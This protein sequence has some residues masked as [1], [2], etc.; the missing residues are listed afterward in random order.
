MFSLID[1]VPIFIKALTGM[2]VVTCNTVEN[3][4]AMI[5]SKDEI[6]LDQKLLL[7]VGK[8]LEDGRTLSDYNIEKQSTL[9]M[10]LSLRGQELFCTYNDLCM[11]IFVV[12]NRFSIPS[13]YILWFKD[14]MLNL[15]GSVE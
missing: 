11:A 12:N 1:G 15:D 3:V 14:L 13:L 9:H 10:V 6:P 4:K 2:E 5:L 8:L 7:F